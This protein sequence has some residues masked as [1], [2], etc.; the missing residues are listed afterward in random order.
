[1]DTLREFL[2]TRSGLAQQQHGH[3]GMGQVARLADG[4]QQPDMT[5]NDS[6]KTR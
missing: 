2:L 1:M 6:G 5:G 4:F 3:A